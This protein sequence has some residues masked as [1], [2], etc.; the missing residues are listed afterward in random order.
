[1]SDKEVSYGDDSPAKA[2]GVS[3]FLKEVT[4]QIYKVTEQR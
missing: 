4:A 2:G 1:V 3:T